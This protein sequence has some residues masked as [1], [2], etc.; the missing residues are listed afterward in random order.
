VLLSTIGIKFQKWSTKTLKQGDLSLVNI[1]DM[2]ENFV[3]NL[4]NF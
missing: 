4:V 3:S 2:R 1:S